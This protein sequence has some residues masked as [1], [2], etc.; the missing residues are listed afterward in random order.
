MQD[1][2]PDIPVQPTVP[3]VVPVR[4]IKEAAAA[5]DLPSSAT[6]C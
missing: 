1:V 6:G 2:E 5:G 4:T 3:V